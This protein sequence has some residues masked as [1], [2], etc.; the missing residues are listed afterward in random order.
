MLPAH[1]LR[2]DKLQSRFPCRAR[3]TAEKFQQRLQLRVN[4]VGKDHDQRLQKIKTGERVRYWKYKTS[5]LIQRNVSSIPAWHSES[6]LVAFC[7]EWLAGSGPAVPRAPF[8]LERSAWTPTCPRRRPW[9]LK[10]GGPAAGSPP[11][12][13]TTVHCSPAHPS[14]ERFAPGPPRRTPADTHLHS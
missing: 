13:R 1:P 5:G 10:S 14:T 7:S 9:T 8:L 3:Q 12:W 11:A 4:Q 2:H 6:L